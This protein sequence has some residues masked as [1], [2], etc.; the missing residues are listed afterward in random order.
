MSTAVTTG[1]DLVK[2]NIEMAL[3]GLRDR[4]NAIVVHDQES[5]I[6]ACQIAL[7]ARSYMRDVKSKLG[8]GIDSA[9]THLQRLQ[10][11]MKA[12]LAP[13]EAIDQAASQKAEGWKAEERRKAQ[14]EQD[15]INREAQRVAAAKAE[16][17]RIEAERIAKEQRKEKVDEIRADLRAGL[18]RKRQAEKLLKLAGADEEAALAAASAAADEAKAAPAPQVTVA[19]NVPKVAGIKARVNFK[20]EVTNPNEVGRAFQIPDLVAIGARVRADKNPEKSMMEIGGI[21]VW[22]EDSI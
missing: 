15:R 17:D 12:Y 1:T 18:I 6:L 2:V 7:D 9:K 4:A 8:P 13:A 5:Y 19:P 22:T 21:R 11:D 14:V 16:E 10:N 20:F 3:T